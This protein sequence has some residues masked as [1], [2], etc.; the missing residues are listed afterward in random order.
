MGL[1]NT[2]QIKIQAVYRHWQDAGLKY[3]KNPKEQY[4]RF[5]KIIKSWKKAETEGKEIISLGDFNLDTDCWGLPRDQMTDHQRIQQPMVDQLKE[6]ILSQ[7]TIK[8]PT[9]TT[10]I[11]TRQGVKS[12]ST[13]DHVYTNIPK[14]I[15]VHVD[16]YTTSDHAMVCVTWYTSGMNTFYTTFR[17][18]RGVEQNKIKVEILSHNLYIPTTL[19]TSPQTI[20]NNIQTILTEVLDNNAPTITKQIN[21][22]Q[23]TFVTIETRTMMIERDKALVKAKTTGN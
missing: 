5:S 14:K 9:V 1:P 4:A 16:S 13:L 7:G 3:T 21:K 20:T 18:F 10:R 23:P 22:K 19:E 11:D 2:R 8:I 17:N 6:V 15:Q 12:H